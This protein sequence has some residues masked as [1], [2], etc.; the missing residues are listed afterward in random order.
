MV[1]GRPLMLTIWCL[2]NPWLSLSLLPV[3]SMKFGFIY[4]KRLMLKSI[5][6]TWRFMNCRWVMFSMI[7]QVVPHI[8]KTLKVQ[9]K[10][11]TRITDALLWI[12]TKGKISSV[13][14]MS[15][16][17]NS[18]KINLSLLKITPTFCCR[19]KKTKE[20]SIIKFFL[21][22]TKNN[23]SVRISSLKNSDSFAFVTYITGN[24][25]V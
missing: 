10:I 5:E 6:D 11:Q 19:T 7:W 2:A 14:T 3:V 8:L 1:N 12:I 21:I 18:T 13:S 23:K 16:K 4:C 9:W 15:R 20:N 17:N 22:H 24:K 25:F